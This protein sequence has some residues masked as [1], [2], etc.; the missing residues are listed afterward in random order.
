MSAPL[1]SRPKA[2]IDLSHLRRGRSYR[3]TTTDGSVIVGEYLGIEVAWDE[4]SILL[5]NAGG[6]E[7]IVVHELVSVLPEA[8]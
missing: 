4:W 6:T 2:T 1:W 7:A 8:A 3:A 5:R